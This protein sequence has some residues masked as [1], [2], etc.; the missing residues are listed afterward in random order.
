MTSF[1]L[2]FYSVLVTAALVLTGVGA[3]TLVGLII[4]DLI[5][6]KVW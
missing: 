5:K 2:S 4:H 3:V 1:S 6:R